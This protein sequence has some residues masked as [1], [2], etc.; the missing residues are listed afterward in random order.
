M[1][2]QFQ[3]IPV[4]GF[5]LG[6]TMHKGFVFISAVAMLFATSL[7]AEEKSKVFVQ[8]EANHT[9]HINTVG[10]SNFM[11]FPNS[12]FGAEALTSFSY[13]E[14]M[15]N[16]GTLEQYLAWQAGFR[17]GYYGAIFA[18]IEAGVDLS[19]LIL[20]Q[21]RNDCCEYSD[22][23][24]EDSVDGYI[25]VGT[26]LQLDVISIE[27][28]ARLRQIDSRYWHSAEHSYYGVQLSVQF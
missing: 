2:W 16:A 6:I 21:E 9:D 11:P 12:D 27:V 25:G 26:G 18:Y 17:M 20:E 4:L 19:E 15:T 14:V 7:S 13:A 3:L 1:A 24:M 10:V 23:P 8:Y 22:D 28:F 5:T